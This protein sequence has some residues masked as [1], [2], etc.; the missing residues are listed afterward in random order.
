MQNTLQQMDNELA[1]L[2]KLHKETWGKI[3]QLQHERNFL[4]VNAGREAARAE[5]AVTYQMSEWNSN[6][7][8]N[9]NF[10]EM[11]P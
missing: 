10:E 1:Q 3:V 8:V 5:P 9:S 7:H 2:S 11:F 4:L 6:G